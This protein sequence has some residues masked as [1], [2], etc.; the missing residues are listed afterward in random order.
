MYHLRYPIRNLIP[1]SRIYPQ[2]LVNTYF[3]MPAKPPA[4]NGIPIGY[5]AAKETYSTQD[6]KFG[7]S[8]LPDLKP[9]PITFWERQIQYNQLDVHPMACTI[10]ASI[11]AVSDLTNY[12]FNL[13][14]QKQLVQDARAVGFGD[15]GWFINGAVDL[16]RQWW[17]RE[18]SSS[19]Q[20]YRVEMGSPDM[21]DVLQ[22]GYSIVTGYRGNSQY[23]DDVAAD[24]QLDNINF[25]ETNYGHAIRMV[26]DKTQTDI[27]RVVVD[28]YNGYNSFNEYRIKI[29]DLS[30]LVQ[31][32]VFFS[33][34]YIF[35][36]TMNN[37]FVDVPRNDKTE[38]YYEAVEWAAQQGLMGGYDDGSFHPNEPINRAQMAVILKKMH[39]QSTLASTPKPE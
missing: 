29:N 23:N 12:R 17:Q 3:S 22:K 2:Q 10:F 35:V 33:D 31:T 5:Y 16:I 38:W 15:D 37:R 28:N 25:G 6:W 8:S 19:M 24:G 27:A 21:V 1:A 34:G 7:S 26:Q 36:N 13:A 14:Q 20:T 4:K 11:G 32:G 39:D 9:A 30:S 18:K